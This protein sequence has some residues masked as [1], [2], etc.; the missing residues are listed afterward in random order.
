M[1][2]NSSL[3]KYIVVSIVLSSM[4]SLFSCATTEAQYGSRAA[5]SVLT[6]KKVDPLFTVFLAGNGGGY[7]NRPEQ[8]TIFHDLSQRIS[9]AGSKS[10]LIWLGDNIHPSGLP[11]TN[12][13]SH[14][15]SLDKLMAQL[16]VTRN[17]K[18]GTI[19]IPGDRDWENDKE[20]GLSRQRK[21]IEGSKD[22][23]RMYPVNGCGIHSSTLSDE[24]ALIT[25]DSQW[26]LENWDKN[27]TINEDCNI[28]NREEF[29]L[30]LEE[31]IHTNQQKTVLIAMHHPIISNGEHG[32]QYSLR[33][34]LFPF[35][36]DVPLPGIGSAWNFIRKTS[37]LYRQ[38]LQNKKYRE[39]T[40]RIRTLIAHKPNILV[41]SA[42]DESLQYIKNHGISQ[43]I[44]G[45]MSVQ[46]AARAIG[47][48]D[49]SFGGYGY[50]Q[51]DV[52]K[53]REA[54]ISFYGLKQGKVQL[55]HRFNL[56]PP[57][58]KK[59]LKMYPSTFNRSKSASVYN[60]SLLGKSRFY[61]FL[62]GKH[63]RKYY[64][65][66]VTV[67]VLSLDTLYGGLSALRWGT[68]EF[69]NSLFAGDRRGREYIMRG[70][71]KDAVGQLQAVAFK[72][73]PVADVLRNTYAE[74]F[75]LD[76]Y[77]SSHPY[78]Q[79]AAGH[80]AR[81]AGI[82]NATP[83]LYYIPKQNA[84]QSF[85]ENFGDAMYLLEEFPANGGNRGETFGRPIAIVGT[86]IVL[87]QTR[88]DE[89]YRIDE[90][91]YIRA[92]LFDMLIGDWDRDEEHWRWGVFPEGTNIVYRPVP[93]GRDQ[94]FTKYDGALLFVVLKNPA[95]RHMQTFRDDIRNI[96]WF[97]SR[98]YPLDVALLKTSGRS[99]WEEQARI[100]QN[101]L[102]DEE[103]QR[104]FN[105]LPAEVRDELIEDIIRK[106]RSR[107]DKLPDFGRR[108]HKVLA[109]TVLVTGTDNANRFK[110]D[111]LP[112]GKT[113]VSMY[114]FKN[115]DEVLLSQRVYDRNLTK[116][117]WVYAHDGKDIFEVNGKQRNPIRL[118]LFGGLDTDTYNIERGNRVFLHDLRSQQSEVSADFRTRTV[119][120]DDY[121]LN[122]YDFRKPKFNAF[123][124]LPNL[125]Y[126]PDDGVKV[127]A[128]L[129]YT[130]NGLKR[131]PYSQRHNLR[132]NYFFAT[133]GYE[134]M[135]KG[136]FPEVLPNTLLQLDAR[137]TSPNFSFNFFGYGNETNNMEDEK[138]MDYNRVKAEIISLSPTIT[139]SGESGSYFLANTRLR[140]VRVQSTAGRFISE[141]L[142]DD[143][144]F[145]RQDYASVAVRYGFENYDVPAN[146][147]LGMKFYL[148]A[149]YE[150][151]LADARKQVPHLEAAVGFSHRIIPSGKLVFASYAKAKAIFS[152]TYEFYQM[153]AIGGDYDVRA[154][155]S[156]RFTGKQSF[157]QS[158]D[159]RFEI[160]QF[161]NIVPLKY[162]L[163]TGFD[164]GRVWLP[165]EH[166]SKW[167]SSYG[168]GVWLNGIN[169]LTAK[170]SWFHSSEGGRISVGLGFGF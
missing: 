114:S 127:G 155:R 62:W 36:T 6:A 14:R 125:G 86:E 39:L 95:F 167:H 165:E 137:Y 16:S 20:T 156:E 82:S 78:L 107:R 76:F 25:I 3:C 42:H 53:D 72:E 31:A 143:E 146:P 142:V 44:S 159:V 138:G 29:F 71:R 96:R 104:S 81:Y 43:L 22:G 121:E 170:L 59:E 161:N 130:V 132:T 157:F 57:Q 133:S 63:Y 30:T 58:K 164:Y 68:D 5:G 92:R 34:Q 106:V 73:Q 147:T 151:N 122:N 70:L 35:R 124:G 140:S 54:W 129:T 24:L 55:I 139:R 152:D 56:F 144:V 163:L 4:F 131:N 74:S 91:A 158:S 65:Q 48:Q 109:R 10:S 136:L 168:G 87:Q 83:S 108:Y 69:S 116:N 115:E 61:N 21:V 93:V 7:E 52:C 98:A 119:F 60:D 105:S 128:S 32:G 112:G 23:V 67:P 148:E 45:S 110:V 111:R 66:K 90:K 103:I 79:F 126:N 166:S 9:S 123:S 80:L 19:F 89:K 13:S 38:D 135:Y 12:A 28:R 18:G 85:N 46:G 40:N 120:N 102:T 64:G 1:K 37:G 100:L 84:L 134:V 17:F 94:A 27:P 141:G 149:G 160:G 118:R 26:Y 153:A 41:V 117:L 88:K 150:V 50:A 162:G 97:N 33:D 77:T 101:E 154:F 15:K 47:K 51:L 8:K 99:D 145:S 2:N 11:D 75:V 49:F 169:L 113:S